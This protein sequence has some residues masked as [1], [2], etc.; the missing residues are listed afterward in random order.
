MCSSQTSHEASLC[1]G[2]LPPALQAMLMQLH[3]SRCWGAIP[4]QHTG[5]AAAEAADLGPSP[6]RACSPAAEHR[7][8]PRMAAPVSPPR[9]AH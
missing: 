2:G 7:V 6:P 5:W 1:V 3:C 9:H 4:W 8:H